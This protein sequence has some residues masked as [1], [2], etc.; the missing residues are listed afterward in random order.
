MTNNMSFLQSTFTLILEVE[1]EVGAGENRGIIKLKV[2]QQAKRGDT[3]LP[4]QLYFQQA[5]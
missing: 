5:S 4:Y 1:I 2:K 3:E